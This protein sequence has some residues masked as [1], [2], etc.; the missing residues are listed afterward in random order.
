M[1]YGCY[2]QL[3]LGQTWGKTPLSDIGLILITLVVVVISMAIFWMFYSLELIIEI[4]EKTIHYEFRPFFR[5]KSIHFSELLDWKVEPI[6]P[7]RQF[8]GYGW[9][10]TAKYKAYIVSGKNALFLE[11]KE[12]R[13]LVLDTKNPIALTA[14]ITKEWQRF[15]EY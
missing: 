6:N 15:K 1:L 7:I 3:V 13:R 8:G 14:A 11:M 4:K 12:G 9:R 10:I 5:T 2:Q